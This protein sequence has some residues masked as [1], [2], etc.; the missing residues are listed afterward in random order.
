MGYL[1]RINAIIKH[2]LGNVKC[3]NARAEA[4]GGQFDWIVSRAVTS[5][6]NFFPW[7]RGKYRRGVLYLKGGDVNPEISEL[8]RRC[9]V[10]PRTISVWP[11]SEWLE[12]EIQIATDKI[13]STP[14]EAE[15]VKSVITEGLEKTNI[16]QVKDAM[17][18]DESSV[19]ETKPQKKSE[20][21]K[22]S[23]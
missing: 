7:V 10:N 18:S 23:R 13:C 16:G 5:L 2:S 6:D 15:K 19:E 8:V 11:V 20:E 1:V 12:E 17:L 14:E 9:G 3:V 22:P 21:T 4:I